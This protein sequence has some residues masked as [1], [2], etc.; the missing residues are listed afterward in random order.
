MVKLLVVAL[1]VVTT[2]C[3]DVTGL[4]Q[5]RHNPPT[6]GYACANVTMFPA[7]PFRMI[8]SSDA[9]RL[10]TTARLVNRY[11]TPH[12]SADTVATVDGRGAPFLFIWHGAGG[13]TS[14][15]CVTLFDS[16]L[17]HIANAKGYIPVA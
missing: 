9:I 11:L 5:Q 14:T 12:R 15:Y 7:S 8:Y 13:D 10:D 17:H 2:A 4:Q 6:A 1:A 3:V 16:L